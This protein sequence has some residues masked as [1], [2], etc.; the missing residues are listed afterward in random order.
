[1]RGSAILRHSK[2]YILVDVDDEAAVL[3]DTTR[4]VY[5]ELNPIARRVWALMEFPIA[6]DM[7]CGI[8]AREY[9]IKES[10]CASDLVPFLTQLSQAGLLSF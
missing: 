3:L 5:Y 1:M 8:I 4:A 2:E 10:Q 9:D 6:F 7:L